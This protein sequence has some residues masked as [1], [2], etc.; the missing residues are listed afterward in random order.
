ML[1]YH[2]TIKIEDFTISPKSIIEGEKNFRLIKKSFNLNN[3]VH[4]K[5]PKIFWYKEEM[6]SGSIK[7]LVR[8]LRMYL[9]I[10]VMKSTSVL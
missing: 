6:C 8:N 3:E 4:F 10:K 5:K 7:S 1:H 9:N 2:C